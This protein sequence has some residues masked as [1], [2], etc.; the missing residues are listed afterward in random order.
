MEAKDTALLLYNRYLVYL[1]NNY[2][3]TE[4]QYDYA[5]Q[6]ALIAVDYLADEHEFYK[7]NYS[8]DNWKEVLNEIEKL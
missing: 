3:Y 8:S 4:K 1:R 7:I 6:C 5:K 2:P